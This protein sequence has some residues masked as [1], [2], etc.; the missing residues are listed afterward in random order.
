MLIS[1]GDGIVSYSSGYGA[2]LGGQL[3]D[4][5]NPFLG[6]KNQ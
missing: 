5:N 2:S 6:L 4:I 1:S 3:Y